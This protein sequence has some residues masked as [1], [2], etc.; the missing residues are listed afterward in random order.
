MKLTSSS[1]SSPCCRCCR[2]C[3]CDIIVDVVGSVAVSKEIEVQ[4]LNEK[5]EITSVKSSPYIVEPDEKFEI[6]VKATD[7]N[8]VERVEIF[9][10]KPSGSDIGNCDENNPCAVTCGESV[11]TAKFE[12]KVPPDAKPGQI[13]TY[14]VL[15]YDGADN[16]KK[17]RKK[18]A[19]V[20]VQGVTITALGKTVV[21]AE[22]RI[23]VTAYHQKGIESIEYIPKEGLGMTVEPEKSSYL[24]SDAKVCTTTFA[25]QIPNQVGEF[26]YD[27]KARTGNGDLIDTKKVTVTAK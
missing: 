4:V 23:S 26:G 1:S 10:S 13:L 2:C 16:P 9:E 20:T 22:F 8:A 17:S 5:P 15:A 27:I 18:E 11:C 12:V 7:D 14:S 24:C 19:T 25:L 3:C 21:N 6:T